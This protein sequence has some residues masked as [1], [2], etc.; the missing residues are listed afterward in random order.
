MNIIQKIFNLLNH[1][2]FDD[3]KKEQKQYRKDHC[4]NKYNSDDWRDEIFW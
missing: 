1:L 3:L 2:W 4:L